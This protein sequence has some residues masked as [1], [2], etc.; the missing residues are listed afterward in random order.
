[1]GAFRYCRWLYG[2][3]LL[4]LLLWVRGGCASV[5][6]DLLLDFERGGLLDGCLMCRIIACFH[7]EQKLTGCRMKKV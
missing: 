3:L 1:M 6:I 4:I 5:L 7:S 2:G